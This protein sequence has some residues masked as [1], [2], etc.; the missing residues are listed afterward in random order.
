MNINVLL[1]V[2]PAVGLR[3]HVSPDFSHSLNY[4][5]RAPSIKVT[6]RDERA[7]NQTGQAARAK[8]GKLSNTRLLNQRL[9]FPTK[10]AK[11]KQF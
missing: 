8:E 1:Q 2:F 6:Q 11:I 4:P 5:C 9:F 10:N 7:L 3:N